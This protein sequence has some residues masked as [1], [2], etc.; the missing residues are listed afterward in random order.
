[1]ALDEARIL[2]ILSINATYWC[3]CHY[4]SSTASQKANKEIV[5]H[6]FAE[7]LRVKWE[8][9]YHCHVYTI[10]EATT[11][12]LSTGNGKI[13]SQALSKGNHLLALLHLKLT[14]QHIII[15]LLN[16]FK[17]QSVKTTHSFADDVSL[18]LYL[19]SR[20]TF[21]VLDVWRTMGW[22]VWG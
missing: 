13:A 6:L 1:M 18:S 19:T 20:L 8:D 9:Q 12:W 17:N 16:Q 3:N 11:R 14:N 2:L 21:W 4:L 22:I 5:W 15:C 10:Y 7:L